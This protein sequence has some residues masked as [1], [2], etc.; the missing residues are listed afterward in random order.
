LNNAFKL[1]EKSGALAWILRRII[2]KRLGISICMQ[3]EDIVSFVYVKPDII[4]PYPC[5]QIKFVFD[6][7][8]K[9]YDIT[10]FKMN[11]HCFN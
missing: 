4:Q 3:T 10:K 1:T 6:V 7:D 11:E 2:G 8:N 5:E 9:M